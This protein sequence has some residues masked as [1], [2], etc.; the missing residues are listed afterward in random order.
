[1]EKNRTV[2]VTG[3]TGYIGSHTCVVLLQA[4]YQVVILD[5]LSNS[6]REV[7][8]AVGDVAGA[9]PVFYEGDLRDGA[10]L[11]RVFSENDMWKGCR[12]RPPA[13]MAIQR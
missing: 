10:D 2:L 12:F 3:G 5:N 6:K 9:A 1:M 8:G 7:A 4:G 13:L 11:E